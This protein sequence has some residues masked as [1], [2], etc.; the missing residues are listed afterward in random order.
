MQ[1]FTRD[2]GKIFGEFLATPGPPISAAKNS[3]IL[4]ILAAKISGKLNF[5]RDGH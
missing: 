1:N 2:L 4:P 3:E 5:A